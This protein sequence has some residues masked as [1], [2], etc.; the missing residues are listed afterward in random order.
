MSFKLMNGFLAVVVSL[1]ITVSSQAA[2]RGSLAVTFIPAKEKMEALV[3][4]E[5]IRSGSRNRYY[6]TLEKTV[7][8]NGW[9]REESG[10]F[11]ENPGKCTVEVFANG[12]YTV[13]CWL[14]HLEGRDVLRQE[15]KTSEEAIATIKTFSRLRTYR[16]PPK[17]VGPLRTILV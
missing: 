14:I 12:Q 7:L 5:L 2:D 10:D 8:S 13:D 15:V 6:E 17:K 3:T 4:V 16:Q 11:Y 9:R 1:V